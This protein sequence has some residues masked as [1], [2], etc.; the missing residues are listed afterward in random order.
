MLL[1][2]FCIF[3]NFSFTL[4]SQV[5]LSQSLNFIGIS[6]Q[7]ILFLDY[8]FQI[9]NLDFFAIFAQVQICFK[10]FPVLHIGINI[11]IV[12]VTFD[13]LLYELLFYL[14][15]KSLVLVLLIYVF[16]VYVVFFGHFVQNSHAGIVEDG[17]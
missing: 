1:V 15:Y 6:L 13:S 4:D 12:L 17:D 2:K 9:D 11:V 3:I 5:L 16:F 7:H 8:W 14:F 10:L